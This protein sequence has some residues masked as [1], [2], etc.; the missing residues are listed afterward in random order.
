M[1][2]LA[3]IIAA[4]AAY[5]FGAVWY[6]SLSRAWM[7]SAGIAMGPDG[8]PAQRSA[9]PFVI[10]A[11]LLVV[12]AGMMRHIFKMAGLDTLVEGVMGGFGLGA[13]VVLPWVAMNHVYA[14]RPRALTLIDGGYAV[15]G[16]TIMGI[17]LS[18]M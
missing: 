15:I 5:A 4:A 13:F 3:V 11:I 2:F 6:M 12:V 17:V 10:G 18:V 8:K 7:T 9:A 1:Q 16:C 14:G